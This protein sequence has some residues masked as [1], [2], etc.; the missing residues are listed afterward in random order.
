MKSLQEDPQ[1][2]L[3]RLDAGEFDD[4]D[5]ARSVALKGQAERAVVAAAARDA[6]A[7]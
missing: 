3:D 2:F 7:A 1:E 5:P 4:L 6:N